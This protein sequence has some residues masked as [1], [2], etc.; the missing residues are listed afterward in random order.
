MAN[1]KSSEARQAYIDKNPFQGFKI[2]DNS[3]LEKLQGRH[4]CPKC[5]KSRKFFCYTCYVPLA[6]L[7]GVLPVVK[8]PLKID[9]IKHKHEI[10]GK[11][12]AGHAAILAPYDVSIYTY[13]DIPDYSDE[14]VVLIFPS[15]QAISIDQLVKENSYDSIV[16]R[17]SEPLEELPKGFNRSTLMKTALKTCDPITVN[18]SN[19]LPINRAIFI[20]STWNQSKGIFKDNRIKKIPCV[21][22]QNRISQFWRHQ[23]G[24]PRWYLATIEAIHQFVLELHLHCWGLN[25]DYKGI[26]NCF[27]E[28]VLKEFDT[29]Y[30]NHPN[31]YN[32]QY[33]NLLYFFQHMYDL[34]HAYYD[35]DNLYAYKRRLM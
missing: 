11:S 20:D 7:E 18:N 31:A 24:S 26:S 13:P 3:V 9:I 21:V 8:L 19:Y 33:D 4:P 15:Q 23:K 32:G 28:T 29:L 1:P 12:T 10:D 34:I 17:N 5:G 2:S 25:P 16:N 35:H 6:E 30:R 27:T 22:I 14:N